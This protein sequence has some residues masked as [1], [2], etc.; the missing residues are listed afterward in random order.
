MLPEG[1]QPAR[2]YSYG[3]VHPV[4]RVLYIAGQI[5][6]DP[7]TG[8]LAEDIPGQWE[9]ALA[10][11]CAVVKAAGGTPQN[12]V[13]LRYNVVGIESYT[14]HVRAVAPAFQ[15]LLPG[16][17]PAATLVSVEALIDPKAKVEIEGV[18]YLA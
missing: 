17:L 13:F 1:W 16:H 4:G 3:M 2:G 12:I 14:Q 15:K 6:T 7:A 18:A 9:Q 10:N 11:V 5:G 8:K